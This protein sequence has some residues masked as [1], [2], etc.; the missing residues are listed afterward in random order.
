M[1]FDGWD[2]GMFGYDDFVGSGVGQVPVQD[3]DKAYDPDGITEPEEEVDHDD[4]Y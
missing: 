4:V 2:D 3:A 1:V